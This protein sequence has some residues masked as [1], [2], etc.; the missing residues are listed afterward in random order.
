MSTEWKH[1]SW[2][3]TLGKW[4]WVLII[5]NSI[6][7]I[8]WG[9]IIIIPLAVLPYGYLLMGYGIWLLLGGIINALIAFFI[10]LPKFSKKCSERDWD[11]LLN[12]VLPIGSLRF[13]WMLL[14]GI[15]LEI[16]GYGWGGL[17][18]LIPAIFL[19]FTGP[20]RY[21]WSSQK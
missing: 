10:I 14:W 2:V 3:S 12:W 17:P 11:S 13:P 19:L 4:A 21:E 7:D 16:F 15:I 20:K 6:I 8:I 1:A 18:V 5:I 9:L